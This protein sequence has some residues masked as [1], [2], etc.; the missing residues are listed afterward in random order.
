[1]STTMQ[2]PSYIEVKSR[3]NGGVAL[4]MGVLVASIVVFGLAFVMMDDSEDSRYSWMKRRCGGKQ[5][6]RQKKSLIQM[7]RRVESLLRECKSLRKAHKHYKTQQCVGGCMSR[8]KK[9]VH[10]NKYHCKNCCRCSREE[11][12]N[13][14]VCNPCRC[15]HRHEDHD[16]DQRSNE[17]A[18]KPLPV[19][20]SAA[21]MPMQMPMPMPMPMQMPSDPYMMNGQY[22]VPPHH[23]QVSGSPYGSP[24][25]G[26]SNLHQQQGFQCKPLPAAEKKSAI[27]LM[28]QRA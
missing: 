24:Y 12:E 3:G 8:K 28:Y 20:L 15:Q 11:R 19:P 10:W 23:H 17:G 2:T 6:K 1:M 13:N 14:G 5:C 16:E 26:Q 27:E 22:P 18:P 4:F 7:E 9:R 25:E 21:P